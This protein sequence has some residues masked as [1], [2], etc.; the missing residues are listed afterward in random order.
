M[1]S[2][3]NGAVR[4]GGNVGGEIRSI[5]RITAEKR[6]GV[7]RRRRKPEWKLYILHCLDPWGRSLTDGGVHSKCLPGGWRPSEEVLYPSGHQCRIIEC[8]HIYRHLHSSSAFNPKPKVRSPEVQMMASSTLVLPATSPDLHNT[9]TPIT[10]T[11]SVVEDDEQSI[12]TIDDL[13]RHRASGSKGNDPIVA[14]PSHGSEYTYYTPQQV[15]RVC[16]VL[17]TL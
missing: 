11:A 7:H 4:A 15:R 2:P 1:S 8:T 17:S 6:V 13:L 5:P 16:A 14:Y 3:Q 10:T 12:H 9:T